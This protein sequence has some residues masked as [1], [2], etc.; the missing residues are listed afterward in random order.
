MSRL[1]LRIPSNPSSHSITTSRISVPFH[2]C[3]RTPFIQFEGVYLPLFALRI[4]FLKETTSHYTRYAYDLI[5]FL[6]IRSEANLKKYALIEA[7]AAQHGV[8]FYPAGRGIGHQIMCEE[9]Y[10]FPGT[11][12]TPHSHM[13]LSSLM[14]LKHRFGPPT[15][16]SLAFSL[17]SSHT[18]YFSM[19]L[20]DG[21]G[22]LVVGSDSHSNM[23]GGLGCLGTPVVR[24]D[25]A[26]IWAT[27]TTWWKVPQVTRGTLLLSLCY[28]QPFFKLSLLLFG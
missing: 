14:H 2:S 24:T 1:N 7:F 8:D 6:I 21:L 16:H 3:T 18:I 13:L 12:H 28:L 10:A 5:H 23:Y 11:R 25:A 19:I 20:M 22:T 4:V 15:I 17:S 26:G 27:S 9:G